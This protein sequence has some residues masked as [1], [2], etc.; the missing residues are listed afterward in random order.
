MKNPFKHGFALADNAKPLYLQY[1]KLEEEHGLAKRAMKVYDQ[2]A[3]ALPDK[4]KLQ[5]Y[6][7]Y[8][9][10]AAEFFGFPKTR[11]IYEQAI[12]PGLPSEDVKTMCIKYAD[13]EKSLEE[14]DRARAIYIFSSHRW[15]DFE[16]EDG[17]EDIFINASKI[18]DLLT[19]I[20]HLQPHFILPENTIYKDSRLKLEETVD[21]LK[22]VR[23]SE[24]KIANLERQLASAAQD[25][26]TRRLGFVSAGVESQS[27]VI[28][29]PDGWKK[30]IA[31]QDTIELPEYDEEEG[32]K[33]V[34]IAQRDVPVAMF[35]DLAQKV[36][37]EVG[38]DG[39]PERGRVTARLAP[40]VCFLC[41]CCCLW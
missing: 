16:V 36:V 38:E 40:L 35:G 32:D 18:E 7:I 15:H 9:A 5:M 34:E 11:E 26:S 25:N 8:I 28:R 2:A 13:L 27:S 4:E 17:N 20:F 23:V 3:K 12:E 24:D 14:I 37:E 22:C 31:D 19:F 1:E 30:I 41:C 21:T 39:M 33:E 6:K 29:T 10:R